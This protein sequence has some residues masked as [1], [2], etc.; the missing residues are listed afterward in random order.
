M[1]G[2]R[3][4]DLIMLITVIALNWQKDV[5]SGLPSVEVSVITG[6]CGNFV[7]FHTALFRIRT[8]LKSRVQLM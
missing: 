2:E 1:Q 4:P 8:K 3:G 6:K 5:M 7:A